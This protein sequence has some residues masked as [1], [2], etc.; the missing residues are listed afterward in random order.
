MYDF[1]SQKIRH[2]KRSRGFIIRYQKMGT[3]STAEECH[4][5]MKEV[6]TKSKAQHLS[7]P[8]EKL[9]QRSKAPDLSQFIKAKISTTTQQKT[10]SIYKRA[11][12]ATRKTDHTLS[13][14]WAQSTYHQSYNT[15]DTLVSQ[16]TNYTVYLQQKN[17]NQHFASN[18]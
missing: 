12:E 17:Q 5:F 4:G 9:G 2:K 7:Y 8:I 11:Q 10:N 3:R 15:L 6:G 18:Q 16:V 1:S 14:D 13:K